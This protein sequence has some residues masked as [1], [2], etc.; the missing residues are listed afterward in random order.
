MFGPCLQQDLRRERLQKQTQFEELLLNVTALQGQMKDLRT[1]LDQLRG[2][3]ASTSPG[4]HGGKGK[5]I[6]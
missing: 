4:D 1:E 2:T 3:G 5:V 6:E